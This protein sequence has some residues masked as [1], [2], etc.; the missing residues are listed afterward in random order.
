MQVATFVCG[1]HWVEARCKVGLEMRGERVRIGQGSAGMLLE[2]CAIMYS[3][4]HLAG[5]NN[6]HTTVNFKRSMEGKTEM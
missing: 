2:L 1:G 5:V 3:E 4:S 6:V